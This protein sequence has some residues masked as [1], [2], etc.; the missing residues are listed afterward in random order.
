MKEFLS[1]GVWG[2]LGYAVAV[3]IFGS[4]QS[5]CKASRFCFCKSRTNARDRADKSKREAGNA[6]AMACDKYARDSQK[7]TECWNFTR[8]LLFELG[9]LLPTLH[10]RKPWAGPNGHLTTPTL[11]CKRGK[12][13]PWTEQPLRHLAWGRRRTRCRQQSMTCLRCGALSTWSLPA[14]FTRRAWECCLLWVWLLQLLVEVFR[15]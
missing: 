5:F 6:K 9:T 13:A 1:L 2:C 11:S 4:C 15:V 12:A 7:Q 14:P 3:L 10:N 8:L